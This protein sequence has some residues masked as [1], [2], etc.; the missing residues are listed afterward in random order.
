MS[1]RTMERLSEKQKAWHRKC[2]G[3]S[4]KMRRALATSIVRS[5]K[6]TLFCAG[7]EW[8]AMRRDITRILADVL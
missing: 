6:G 2:Y 1:K 5:V 7:E 4:Y 3:G 8:E